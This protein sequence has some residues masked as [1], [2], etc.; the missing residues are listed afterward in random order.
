MEAPLH[1]YFGRCPMFKKIS[2][3]TIKVA[4]LEGKRK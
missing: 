3:G 4:P 2:D 1:F